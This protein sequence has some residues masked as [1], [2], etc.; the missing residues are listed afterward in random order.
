MQYKGNGPK[1]VHT[2]DSVGLWI[3]QPPPPYFG[4]QGVHQIRVRERSRPSSCVRA[5]HPTQSRVHWVR[6]PSAD[7]YFAAKCWHVQ[8]DA[9]RAALYHVFV[10]YLLQ[11][12]GSEERAQKILRDIDSNGDGR[13]DFEEFSEMMKQL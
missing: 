13:I 7:A 11:V 2:L 3:S 9:G 10:V 6:V 12:L 5:Y 8:P 4:Q 1:E